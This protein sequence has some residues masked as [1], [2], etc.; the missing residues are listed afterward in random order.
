MNFGLVIWLRR[1]DSSSFLCAISSCSSN[2][3]LVSPSYLFVFII[4]S[5]WVCTV[6]Y[7]CCFNSIVLVEKISPSI[8]TSGIGRPAICGFKE[9][10][11]CLESPC[12]F[13]VAKST[14]LS[15]RF[16]ESYMSVWRSR[17]VFH[18][19]VDSHSFSQ[20]LIKE[21]CPVHENR[22]SSS[23]SITMLGSSSQSNSSACETRCSDL[24][25][26]IVRMK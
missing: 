2:I 21:S 12:I 9:P 7:C 26:T 23:K 16:I 10:S 24:Y 15:S 22:S 6:S 13:F 17:L 1:M 8:S 14:R 25:C 20:K 3:V 4:F 19:A 11:T 18:R 5:V